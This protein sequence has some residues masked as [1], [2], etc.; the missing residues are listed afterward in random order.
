[1]QERNVPGSNKRAIERRAA[2]EMDVQAR[3]KAM[4]DEKRAQEQGLAQARALGASASNIVGV[5]SAKDKRKA[6][7]DRGGGQRR[8]GI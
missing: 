2:I 1:M 4:A 7:R 6:E 3:A 5:V 8:V